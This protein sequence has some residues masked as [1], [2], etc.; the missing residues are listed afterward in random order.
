[1]TA[2][3]EVRTDSRRRLSRSCPAWSGLAVAVDDEQRVVDA[4][5]ETDHRGEDRREG[6]D[7]EVARDQQQQGATERD[8]DTAVSSGRPAAIREPNAKSRMT[9]ATVTP[10]PSVLGGSWPAN[11]RN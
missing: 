8:A 10:K 7:V 11:A 9:S 5:P 2:R 4:D 1:M 6:R 3:P